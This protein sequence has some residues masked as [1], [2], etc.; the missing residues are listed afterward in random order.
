MR[1]LHGA[2]AVARRAMGPTRSAGRRCPA[3]RIPVVAAVFSRLPSKPDHPALELQILEL[4]D[5]RRT[6]QRLRD[7]NRDGPI[8]SFIDGPVTANKLLAVHTAWGRT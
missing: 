6:F 3:D 7:Q 5:R 8:W 2:A 4:W 1:R